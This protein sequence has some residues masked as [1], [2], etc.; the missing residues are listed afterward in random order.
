MLHIRNKKILIILQRH[1]TYRIINKTFA[2]WL[3][4]PYLTL[5]HL[6]TCF[7]YL[8]TWSIHFHN[9]FILSIDKIYNFSRRLQSWKYFQYFWLPLGTQKK[10]PFQRITKEKFATFPK[11][12]ILQFWQK[13][14][15]YIH[16]YI[17]SHYNPSVI[18][19]T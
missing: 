2:Y 6:I 1:T 8:N 7:R 16:K 9:V 17:I 13:H 3:K 5:P 12:K 15:I 19:M 14:S 11:S 10:K 4:I 18:I